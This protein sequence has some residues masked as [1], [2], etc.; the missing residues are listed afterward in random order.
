MAYWASHIKAATQFEDL[1]PAHHPN[2][3]LYR[4]YREEYGG[5]QTL[6]LMLRL[7]QGDIFNAKTLH[8]IQDMTREIDRWPASI[9]T[10]FF[11]S[12]RIASFTR[13]RC[14]VR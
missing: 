1:F 11:R 10:R 13:A 5:A 7:K 8:A 2:T 4:E 3:K 12:P 14:P 6:I 9:T